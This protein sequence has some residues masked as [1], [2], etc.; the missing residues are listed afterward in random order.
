MCDT[1]DDDGDGV[2]DEVEDVGAVL[3]LNHQLCCLA[4]LPLPFTAGGRF[5][6]PAELAL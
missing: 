3:F 2:P 1:K 5:R 4:F 6:K